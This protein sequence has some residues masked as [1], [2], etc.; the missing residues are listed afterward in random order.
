MRFAAA[1]TALVAMLISA[2]DVRAGVI[3]LFNLPGNT[4]Q[5]TFG[6]GTNTATVFA[7]SVTADDTIWASLDFRVINEESNGE[8]G[9]FEFLITSS[10]DPASVVL[11]GTNRLPDASD[12][13][14]QTTVNH[15]GGG[16]IDFS[17]SLG[18]DVE[19]N[20]VLFFVLA[21]I[22]P[23]GTVRTIANAEVRA[24]QF[25]GADQYTDGEFLLSTEVGPFSNS[26]NYRSRFDNNQDL[27]FRAEFI[28]PVPVPPAL[29]L[30]A[31]GFGAL[32]LMS[33]RARRG[34]PA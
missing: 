18:L 20:E 3:D 11:P 10:R 31:I 14:F 13:R 7:Q 19:V 32:F 24:T 9:T 16:P 1:A 2:N 23:D 28:S 17:F 5:G 22:P 26:I 8:V 4:D 12:I 21:T 30:A 15:G 25:N 29:P 6:G 33:V 34:Y 27:A